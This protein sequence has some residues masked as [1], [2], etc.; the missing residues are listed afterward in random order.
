MVYKAVRDKSLDMHAIGLTKGEIL[1][2]DQ[3]CDTRYSIQVPDETEYPEKFQ[4]GLEFSSCQNLW[5]GDELNNLYVYRLRAKAAKLVF[6]A[7]GERDM[8]WWFTVNTVRRDT[9]KETGDHIY[10]W[11]RRKRVSMYNGHLKK[12]IISFGLS[13]EKFVL[14]KFQKIYK[15]NHL[16]LLNSTKEFWTICVKMRK[17]LSLNINDGV[18]VR[19]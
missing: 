6:K 10:V 15:S 11:D 4:L 13:L 2:L 18:T 8:A 3:N 7:K 17:L 12:R 1:I 19:H 14:K 9:F 5:V 16:M